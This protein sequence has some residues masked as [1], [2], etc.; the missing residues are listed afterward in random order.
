MSRIGV[1]PIELPQGVTVDIGERNA[2]TVKGPKGTLA[3]QLHV[4]MI[5]ERD[6][7]TV[8]VKRPSEAK[9]HKSLHGLT[10]TLIANM[11]V[12]VSEGFEK[13]LELRGVGYRAELDGRQLVLQVGL[14]H[15]VSFDPPEG[16][17]LDV[18]ASTAR[19]TGSMPTTIIIVRGADKERVG[20]MAA[21]IRRIRKVEPFKGKGI[22]Y[23]GEYVR[24]KAGK[25]GNIGAGTGR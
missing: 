14:S 19:T 24:R 21:D 23:Q 17:E 11:V 1:Q 10:R 2:V 12:G 5:L 15:P 8:V 6:D 3:R 25:A 9:T 4:A 7:G 18:D 13:R 16:I 22:R 20:Q